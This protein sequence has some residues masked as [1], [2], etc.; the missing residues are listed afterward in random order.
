MREA[1]AH[2]ANSLVRQVLIEKLAARPGVAIAESSLQSRTIL[3]FQISGLSLRAEPVGGLSLFG[4]RRIRR[5]VD[6]DIRANL[7]RDSI[8]VFAGACTGSHS[9]TLDYPKMLLAS[10]TAY[11]DLNPSIPAPAGS[12]L[13]DAA[14]VLGVAGCLL[15]FLFL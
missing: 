4:K 3:E 2:S 6:Y 8:L 9:D 14:I 15:Y 13:V 5:V 1:S 11:P 7:Y 10:T 12:T